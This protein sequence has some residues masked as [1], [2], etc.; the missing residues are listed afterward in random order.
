MKIIVLQDHLRSGGTERHSIFL[1]RG[2]GQ[3]GHESELVTFRPGGV[4]APSVGSPHRSLQPFD[5]GIDW[6]APGLGAAFDYI[7]GQADGNLAEGRIALIE[8]AQVCAAM[9]RAGLV[10]LGFTL[11]APTAPAAR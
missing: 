4:L 5:T 8:N 1:S 3:M 2:L 9:T 10:A 11:F 6:L 7:A